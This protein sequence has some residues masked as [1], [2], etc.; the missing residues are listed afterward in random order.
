[1]KMTCPRWTNGESLARA[2]IFHWV[3]LGALIGLVCIIL[4]ALHLNTKNLHTLGLALGL[5]GFLDTNLLIS[6][7]RNAHVRGRILVEYR[8]YCLLLLRYACSKAGY[9]WI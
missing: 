7:T 2:I 8:L 9:I 6:V 5:Q 4:P 3:V 1:M